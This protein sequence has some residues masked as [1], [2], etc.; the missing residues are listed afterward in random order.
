MSIGEAGSI[1]TNSPTENAPITVTLTEPLTDPVFALSSTNNGGNQFVLRI[2]G[3]TLDA[4]GNTTE[5]TFI[6]EEWE[7]LDGPHGATETIN[8]LAVEEGVHTLPDGRTIE[9]GT[10]L[11]DNTNSSVT[12]A[13]NFATPP[14]V[15]TSVMSEN[16]TTTVDSDP[17]NITAS[18]F[19]VRLQEEEGEDGAH[20]NETVGWIAIQP[21][22]DA[23]SGTAEAFDGVDENTDTLG[24]GA[25]FTNSIVLA[26]TQTINGGDTA[27][28]VIDGQTNSTVGVFIEEEQSQNNETNHVDETV[29]I[30]AFEDGVIPCFASDTQLLTPF[31]PRRVATLRIG[32]RVLTVDRGPQPIRWIGKR[33]LFQRD[34]DLNPKLRPVRISAGALGLGL[35]QNDLLVSCQHRMLVSSKI[36]YRM[37]GVQDVLISAQKLTELPGIY[38]DAT[39]K[40]VE[41]HHVLFDEHEVVYAEGAPSESLYT[42]REVLN[43]LTEDGLEEVY[44]IFPDLKYP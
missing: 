32:D 10:T 28:V 18:G 26:E 16:D 40:C 17:L 29:G 34:L 7:Y 12:L 4:N 42:G 9:A 31:G 37:F 35:P 5:F 39:I 43:A 33:R 25:T 27:T 13:G 3:Q 1:T 22:G 41:Y 23:T 14:V 11:A 15:L 2:I 21:G 20:A 24:L 36:A 30:V 44:S 6:I 19:N 8:W 38:V